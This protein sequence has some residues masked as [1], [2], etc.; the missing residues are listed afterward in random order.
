MIPTFPCPSVP[1]QV[2]TILFLLPHLLTLRP[3]PDVKLLLEA[4]KVA[5][6]YYKW[7]HPFRYLTD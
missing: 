1:E 6:I 5:S 4:S 3:T 7:P 2:A